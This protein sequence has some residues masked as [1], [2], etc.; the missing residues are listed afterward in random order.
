MIKISS[1]IPFDTAIEE[2]ANRFA[3][4]SFFEIAK[5]ETTGDG[6]INYVNLLNENKSTVRSIEIVINANTAI[7]NG[8]D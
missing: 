6:E 4:W 5:V 1:D 3:D 2:A 7:I 8:L